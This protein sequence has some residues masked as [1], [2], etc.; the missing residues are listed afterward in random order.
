[1]LLLPSVVLLIAS[2]V[3]VLFR[4]VGDVGV[5]VGVVVNIVVIVEME[6]LTSTTELTHTTTNFELNFVIKVEFK[7]GCQL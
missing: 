4:V 7:V 2:D 6:C 1:M 5:V 3:V